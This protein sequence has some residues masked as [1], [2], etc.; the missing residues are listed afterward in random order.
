MEQYRC[1]EKQNFVNE[2]HSLVPLR[3]EDRIDI[4]H[5][6]NSQM[7]HLRQ[8]EILTAEA[9][10]QYFSSII[11]K[12]FEEQKPNQI[13]FSF[14][15]HNKC[16]GYGGLVHINWIDKHAEI[17][18]IMDTALEPDF[19]E[20]NWLTYLSLIEPIAFEYLKFHK[21]FV[22][23][24]DLRPHLYRMLEKGGFTKEATL[25]EHCLFNGQFID[26]IIH[27]KRVEL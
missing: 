2:N 26:V 6:R 17:S 18:F 4:M 21:I 16:I 5:W 23:A 8:S 14:L 25:K 20:E 7:Y 13:L 9:Q 27:Q 11:A 1:L 19:F 12:Q 15:H 22:Y 3:W 10:D 24:F